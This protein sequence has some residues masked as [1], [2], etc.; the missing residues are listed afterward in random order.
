MVEL[1]VINKIIGDNS[2]KFIIDN[3]IDKSYFVENQ[4]EFIFIDDYYKRYGQV[5]SPETFLNEFIEFQTFKVRES[6]EYLLNEIKQ[7]KNFNTLKPIL[8]KIANVSIDD[9][10]KAIYMMKDMSNKIDPVSRKPIGT[11]IIKTAKHRYEEYLE[12]DIQSN[13]IST[14]FKELDYLTGGWH[15]GEELVVIFARTGE[16]KSFFLIKTLQEAWQQGYRVGFLTPEMSADRVGYRF[17]SASTNISNRALLTGN[18]YEEKEYKEYVE[19]IE[20]KDGFLVAQKTDFEDG[21]VTVN[22]IKAWV[23]ES[24]LDILGIDGLSYIRDSRANRNDSE[25]IRLENISHDLMSLSVELGIPVLVVV[26][27]N[28]SGDV[29]D[30]DIL[31]L[32]SVRSSDGIAHNASKVFSIVYRD[33]ILKLGTAKFRDGARDTVLKYS[34]NPDRAKYIYIPDNEDIEW[35]NDDKEKLK[36]KFEGEDKLF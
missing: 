33:T 1:Q 12:T 6:E 22:K 3:N 18:K 19:S 21:E 7:H 35:N 36:S 2:F 15:K 10:E 29:K 20:G 4:K 14:G 17:D 24:Q 26:Q 34:W 28:R 16:G 32:S 9:P 27:A 8:E 13:F 25:T 5:P 11:D 30:T 31:S 23:K